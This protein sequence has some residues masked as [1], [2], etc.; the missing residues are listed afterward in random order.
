MPNPLKSFNFYFKTEFSISKF[1]KHL[2]NIC[3]VPDIILRL[4]IQL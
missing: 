2:L 1:K 4:C 3:S